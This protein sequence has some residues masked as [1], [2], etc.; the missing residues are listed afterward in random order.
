M[1]TKPILL[2]APPVCYW[3]LFIPLSPCKIGINTHWP[4]FAILKK[5]HHLITSHIMI[6]MKI[7]L[8]IVGYLSACLVPEYS[9]S[10]FYQPI[11]L[12]MR[13]AVV[14]RCPA[15]FSRWKV[16]LRCKLKIQI[17]LFRHQHTIPKQS[18]R[19]VTGIGGSH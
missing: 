11:K 3:L 4:R 9:I 8:I 15:G 18:F 17:T 7:V 10:M 2:T 12:V 13:F 5:N 14:M 6:D 16:P 1:A 19:N